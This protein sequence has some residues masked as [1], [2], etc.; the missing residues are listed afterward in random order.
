M[1]LPVVRIYE[2]EH[3][4]REAFQKLKAE[5]FPENG[6]F[7]MTPG[8]EEGVSGSLG[9]ALMAGQRLGPNATRFYADRLRNGRSLVMT[10]A[11][12]GYSKLAGEI[13]DG[14]GTVDANLRVPPEDRTYGPGAPLSDAMSLPVLSK[15]ASPFSDSIGINTLTRGR[16]RARVGNW[17]T[18]LG[19]VF[20]P[21]TSSRFFPGRVLPLLMGN[22]KIIP[23][24]TKA[25]GSGSKRSMVGM[26]L[27]LNN[28]A[29][30]SSAFG[31]PTLVE[32]R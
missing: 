11:P 4:A 22:A 27:L 31:I 23:L 8:G 12:F 2:S 20:P 19:R 26:P 14:C 28:P 30:L 6:T 5:G 29:P 32:H 9:A 1:V 3:Q 13:M 21:L 16:P 17:I 15:G 10:L 24:P 7:L 18:F 25:G